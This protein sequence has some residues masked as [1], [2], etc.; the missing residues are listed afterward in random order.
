MWNVQACLSLDTFADVIVEPAASRVSARSPLGY[1]QDPDAN[2][3]GAAGLVT[4]TGVLLHAAAT[5]P[6]MTS[7]AVTL[8][9]R[10]LK[11]VFIRLPFQLYAGQGRC[12]AIDGE[13][14]VTTR[15]IQRPNNQEEGC[16]SVDA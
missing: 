6:T 13:V 14:P 11:L 16:P 1:G 4:V 15:E 9:W 7:T 2:G 5:N 12:G 3:L 10:P 8:T